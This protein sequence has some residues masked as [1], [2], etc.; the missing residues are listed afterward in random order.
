MASL[1]VFVAGSWRW[2]LVGDASLFHY[3]AFLIDHGFVPYRQIVEI[4][5]PGTYFVHWLAIHTLGGGALSWRVFDLLLTA[6]TGAAMIAIT[7]PYSVTSQRWLIGFAGAGLL[8]LVHGQDGISFLGERDQVVAALFA[9]SVAFLFAALRR[10]A[11]CRNADWMIGLSGFAAGLAATIKPWAAPA[12]VLLLFALVFRLKSLRRSYARPLLYG[13]IGFL[14]PG[15]LV[16][17]YLLSVH[18]LGAFFATM[19]GPG[20]Y[21]NSMYRKPLG[22]L[23]MH[24]VAPLGPLVVLWLI[25][26]CFH[27]QWNWEKWVL[28]GGVLF[29]LLNYCIQ[30]RGFPYHR[31]PLLVFLLMLMGIDFAAALRHRMLR[32]I[33]ALA[34]LYALLFLAPHCALKA[35][36]Y[37]WHNQEFISMLTGDLNNLGGQK[38]SGKVQ[39]LDTTAGCIN[40][41]YRDRLVQA[42]GYIYDC[43]LYAP[44]GSERMDIVGRY[45]RDFFRALQRNPPEVFV[46]TDQ[47]CQT[48]EQSYAKLK[49]WPALD[50]L[51]DAQYRLYAER[52]PPDGVYWWSRVMKPAGYRIYVRR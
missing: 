51:L 43:Y 49:R 3:V 5:M 27:R 13:I 39:C 46:V 36:H 9:I 21:Y 22:F 24:S 7:A 15:L 19:L 20:L 18:A 38:L 1:A 40:T 37:D 35:V 41:L 25:V 10:N 30:G 12:G 44:R 2:P 4:N 33:A 6:A 23:L 52:T 50:S 34:S 47:Y 29:G 14:L 8:A 45:R 17:G 11:D 42:T 16:C 48:S 26:L 31:Y 28:A 32:Y